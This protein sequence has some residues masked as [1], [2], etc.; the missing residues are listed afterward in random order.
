MNAFRII[1]NNK[2]GS[3]QDYAVINQ[4]P[5]VNN[6]EKI[7]SN[8]YETLLCGN[9]G[10]AEFCLPGSYYGMCS[11][12]TSDSGVGVRVSHTK[13]VT[14][15]STARDGT[16][17]F[18]TTLGLEKSAAGPCFEFDNDTRPNGGYPGAFEIVTGIFDGRLAAK[19]ESLSAYVLM[20]QQLILSVSDDCSIGLGGGKDGSVQALASFMPEPALCYQVQPSNIWYVTF[21]A[22]DKGALVDVSQIVCSCTIDL[23][24]FE[25]LRTV[26][27]VHDKDG[28][29]TI[30]K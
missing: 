16:T 28:I 14:L 9:G 1:I 19:S 17:I 25:E 4:A 29:L 27:I 21:G 7:W 23:I 15:G 18:G 3:A 5:K 30:Q 8:V 6:P 12:G 11:T 26:R 2:S 13:P 10:T 22:W 24:N 20:T